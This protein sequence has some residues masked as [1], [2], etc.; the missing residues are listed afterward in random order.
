[1]NVAGSARET[2]QEK[3]CHRVVRTP[4]GVGPRCGQACKSGSSLRNQRLTWNDRHTSNVCAPSGFI[5]HL[6]GSRSSKFR[7]GRWPFLPSFSP[8]VPPFRSFDPASGSVPLP[9][10][11]LPPPSLLWPLFD[12]TLRFRSLS[13]IRPRTVLLY[14]PVRAIQRLKN[15]SNIVRETCK[16]I[17]LI[18]NERYLYFS[19][20]NVLIISRARCF[21]TLAV[22][23][24]LNIQNFNV[25]DTLINQSNFHYKF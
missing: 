24:S 1:M 5:S 12:C 3:K 9:E 23:G 20:S 6:R 22:S 14:R 18:R 11:S 2:Y 7:L 8:S 16:N 17:P 25:V 19:R 4:G 21:S 13:F 10:I 15:I